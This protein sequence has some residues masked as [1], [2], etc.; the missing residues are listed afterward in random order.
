MIGE[1]Q[2]FLRFRGKSVLLDSNLLLVLLAGFLGARGFKSFKR[3]SG[4]SYSDHEL[5]VQLLSSFSI[6]LT[7]PHILTEVCNLA[8]SLTGSLKL[9]WDE[10][11]AALIRSEKTRIGVRERWVSAVELSE[12]PEFLPFGVA[13]TAV[14]KLASE[15]LVV[16]EDYRLAGFLNSRGIPVLNFHDLRRLPL[17]DRS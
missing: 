1:E 15:A 5:L 11:F 7:T 10:N 17:N 4:Y 16:T 2:L 8:D 14:A 9:D 6:L 12:R 13:D 3:V